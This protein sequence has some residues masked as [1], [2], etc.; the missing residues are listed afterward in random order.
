[1]SKI[2]HTDIWIL[3]ILFLLLLLTAFGLPYTGSL[4]AQLFP[5]VMQPLYQRES[6][7][8]LI[9]AHLFLVVISSLISIILAVFAAIWV[10]RP[11]GKEFEP[12][13]SS[14]S[15][16]GQTFPPAAVL[17]IA[18]PMVG[19]GFWPALLALMI[20]GLLPIVENAV[21]GFKNIPQDVLQAAQGMGMNAWQKLILVELPLAMPLVIAGIR[22][23]VLIN[24]GTAT[25]SATVGSKSLGTPI[26]AGLVNHNMAYVI[27]GALP[28]ALLAIVI[29]RLFELFSTL[30]RQPIS[31]R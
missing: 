1:M 11:S 20:Y 7:V 26:I 23:S 30:F 5:D 29:D 21:R 13:L 4:F 25:I 16:I 9:G 2:K 18:V 15:A 17:A 8:Y 14:C 10:T 12:L 6:F 31:F 28:V 3:A 19:F 22:I 27:Q 24:I